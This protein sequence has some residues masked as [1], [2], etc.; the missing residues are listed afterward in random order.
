MQ[1]GLACRNIR[2]SGGEP[3]VDRS[4]RKDAPE[5]RKAELSAKERQQSSS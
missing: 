2:T 3:A 5:D 1:D 4:P